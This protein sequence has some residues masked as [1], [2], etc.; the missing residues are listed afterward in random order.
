MFERASVVELAQLAEV[1][2]PPCALAGYV[3]TGRLAVSSTALVYT[4]TGEP[5]AQD[6]GVLK[7]TS[8]HHAGRLQWELECLVRCADAGVTGVVQPLWRELD[9]LPVPE[10]LDAH[11]A[12]L[13]LPFLSGGDL[14]AI[15]RASSKE[16]LAL[17]AALRLGATLRHLLE[18]PEPMVHG[19]LSMR[20]VLLPRPKANL[21]ELTLIDFGSAKDLTGRSP[22]EVAELC[23][24]DVKAFGS[25]LSELDAEGPL[26]SLAADCRQGRY[27]SCADARLW[28]TLQRARARDPGWLAR[29]W[30]TFR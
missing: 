2:E 4:A 7:L 6:E 27:T 8:T 30:T 20:S 5:F 28:R 16:N 14:N 23:L 13:P 9:W 25:I 24:K 19:S 1:L 15:R 12:A 3:L 21:A 10:L 22:H 11:V 26:K 18:L 17:E 29:F